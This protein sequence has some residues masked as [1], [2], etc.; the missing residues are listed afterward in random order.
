MCCPK[1]DTSD[2]GSS[3][4]EI[5]AP[6][7][8]RGVPRRLPRLGTPGARIGRGPPTECHLPLEV[9]L[10][11]AVAVLGDESTAA[12]RLSDLRSAHPADAT[13][14]NLLRTLS[15]QLDTCCRLPVH[16][17]EAHAEGYEAC[18]KTFNELAEVER[19][20]F[21]DLLVCLRKHLEA[22]KGPVSVPMSRAVAK[23]GER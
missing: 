1:E 3:R 11:E 18:A 4:W 10:T 19:R 14:Q 13:L 5:P 21:D 20:S 17:Y 8:P 16:E 12:R 23:R 9:G 15:A 22:T 6:A 7:L 2:E